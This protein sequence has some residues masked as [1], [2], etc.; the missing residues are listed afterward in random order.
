MAI[1]SP[2]TKG[3]SVTKTKPLYQGQKHPT[4]I[5]GEWLLGDFI[6]FPNDWK[7]Y[8]I[9]FIDILSNGKIDIGFVSK[10]G[11]EG[12]NFKHNLIEKHDC[13]NITEMQRALGRI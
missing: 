3:Q 13:V 6:F 1:H 11:K 5:A 9:D 7:V 12:V 10:D 2:I 8:K 4:N